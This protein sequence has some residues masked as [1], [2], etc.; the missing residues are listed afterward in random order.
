MHAPEN[1]A[2]EVTVWDAAQVE[3]CLGRPAGNV[4]TRSV[5]RSEFSPEAL[6]QFRH[7]RSRCVV[8]RCAL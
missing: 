6:E 8:S 4:R 3:M 7:P 5:P 2:G 1:R